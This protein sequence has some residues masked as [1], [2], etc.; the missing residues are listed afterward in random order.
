MTEVK[1]EQS[2]NE[3][4]AELI[5][6]YHVTFGSRPGKLV[7]ED[8]KR[9]GFISKSTARFDPPEALS[10]AFYEGRRTVVL[11]IMDMLARNPVQE[12]QRPNTYNE[13]KTE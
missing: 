4:R 8:L 2:G 12:A 7:L 11:E 5:Q 13:E 3:Q 10:L 1:N 6:A 9:R